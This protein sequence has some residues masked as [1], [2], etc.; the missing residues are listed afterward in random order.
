MKHLKKIMS[1]VLLLA[2]FGCTKV[3]QKGTTAGTVR[4]SLSTE[5]NLT[6]QTKS[7]V[8]DYTALPTTDDFT[9]VITPVSASTTFTWTGNIGDWNSETMVPAGTYK[10][11]AT[12]GSL[13][14]EGF[15]KPFFAGETEFSITAQTGDAIQPVDVS[16]E[17]SLA[18][19]VVL[20]N[21]TDNF[22]NYYNDY[23]FKLTRDNDEIVTFIKGEAKAA[24]IDP[25]KFTLEGD[26]VRGQKQTTFKKDY[27]NLDVA[28]AY[29]ILFDVANVGGTSITISFNDMVETV[30]LGDLELNE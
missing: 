22:K 7:A 14:E 12:Y 30:E 11:T 20:V 23:T 13:E 1:I 29:T 26:I 28:T 19:A 18:N 10:V 25:Y 16:I 17:V 6:D 27:S 8:S 5:L 15:D 24:F 21:C 4:F 2:S 9:I 3:E